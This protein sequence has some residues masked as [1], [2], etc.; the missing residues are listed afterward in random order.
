MGAQNSVQL[1]PN[2]FG[3]CLQPLNS[4]AAL[5]DD[6]PPQRLSSFQA[7][8]GICFAWPLC[9]QADSTFMELTSL[10]ARPNHLNFAFIIFNEMMFP[11]EI[12]R[13][14]Y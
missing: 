4:P 14:V 2:F 13:L 6:T 9:S 1:F 12:R 7:T 3:T 11:G 5:S 10:R 8:Y